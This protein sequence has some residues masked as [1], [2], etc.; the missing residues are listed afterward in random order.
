[1]R[2]C[3]SAVL[4][5]ALLAGCGGGGADPTGAAGTATVWVTRDR[6]A[7][8][9]VQKT[10]PAGLTAMQA[11]DRVADVKTRYGG[12]FVQAVNGIE[13]DAGAERDW[14]YF[15]NGIEADRGAVDVKLRDGD[16]EWWDYRSWHG[17]AISV[18][19]VVGAFP[20]PFDSGDTL[21]VTGCCRRAAAALA[22]AMHARAGGGPPHFRV[23]VKRGSPVFRGTRD[24]RTYRFVI[25]PADALRLAKDPTLARF[26]YEGLR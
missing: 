12:R 11:L 9:L 7:Q 24:G 10:V 15:V 23:E 22:K 26:R 19:V 6:G 17:G 18:P 3:L 8:V 14:F 5:A 16:V 20:K 1:V 25:G 21:V 2:S 13:G 4:A